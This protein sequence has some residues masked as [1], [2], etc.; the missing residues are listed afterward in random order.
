MTGKLYGIGV[1][2][3][4]PELVT[5]KAHRILQ[6]V[7]V[8]A[9]PAP[10]T[11]ESFA[12]SIVRASLQ[13]SQVE[14]PIVIP[15]R[16]ERF[17]AREIYDHAA[18]LIATHLEAGRDVGVLCEGDPFFYGS[19]MYLFER[20]GERFETEIVPGV[21]SIMAGAS[22]LQRPLAARND[23]L[24]VIPAPLSDDA[25]R[26][27]LQRSDAVAI[28]KIGRHF[29]R[30]R[31]LI[32]AEGLT[33]SAGYLQHVSLANQRIFPLGDVPGDSAPYFSI[34]LVYK[35]AENWIAA[36]EIPVHRPGEAS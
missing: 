16:V 32:E 5:L 2:P 14:I 24:T 28:I 23:V 34:I 15:M 1:G 35:G 13:A 17:P 26:Q 10:D 6:Q 33:A 22:A 20:L 7:P 4:D 9:Y 25:I 18:G 29:Q 3:G 30:V 31:K 8:I 19:F 21:S 27:G 11:G 12:R 36:R